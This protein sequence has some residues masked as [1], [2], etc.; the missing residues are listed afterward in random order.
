MVSSLWIANFPT[1]IWDYSNSR[2][3]FLKFLLVHIEHL[4][5][6][7]NYYWPF[8]RS[9]EHVQFILWGRHLTVVPLCNVGPHAVTVLVIFMKTKSASVLVLFRQTDFCLGGLIKLCCLLNRKA[10]QL[11][12]VWKQHDDTAIFARYAD[13]KQCIWSA[14]QSL[15]IQYY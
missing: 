6:C 14:G 5:I 13:A 4:R 7:V 1:C 12:V 9:P 2:R 3:L 15:D 10:L 11:N 8:L